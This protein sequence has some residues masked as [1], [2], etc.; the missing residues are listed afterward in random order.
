VTKSLTVWYLHRNAIFGQTYTHSCTYNG[1]RGSR[2]QS[3]S[4]HFSHIIS[5][6]ESCRARKW[7][8]TPRN[9]F[10]QDRLTVYLYLYLWLPENCS[11]N[12]W[13]RHIDNL[14]NHKFHNLSSPATKY[15]QEEK[16]NF[17]IFLAGLEEEKSENG[18]ANW[19]ILASLQ[20]TMLNIKVG[21]GC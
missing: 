20:I 7:G 2:R 5:G 6:L 9:R 18:W 16:D 13:S 17:F 4:S 1:N 10:P 8:L 11:A 12:S 14:F 19:R 15:G 3:S 21:N